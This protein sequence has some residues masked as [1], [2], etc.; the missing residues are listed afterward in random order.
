MKETCV[1]CDR[2]MP[3]KPMTNGDRIRTMSDEQLA[4]TIMCPNDTGLAEIAC[5][6]SDDLNCAQ[7]TP[8][9]LQEKENSD[10]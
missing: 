5:D 9:W 10:A 8:D 1:F 6:H 7:C 2:P 4:L 3:G